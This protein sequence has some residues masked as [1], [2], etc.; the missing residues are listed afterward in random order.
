MK[1]KFFSFFFLVLILYAVITYAI[2]LKGKSC[3]RHDSPWLLLYGSCFFLLSAA[4]PLGRILERSGFSAIAVPFIWAGSFWFAAVVYLFLSILIIDLFRI[5]NALFPFFPSFL[6]A[7]P[8]RTRRVTAWVVCASVLMVIFAGYINARIPCLTTLHLTVHKRCGDLRSLHIVSVSD[9]H[10]GTI[11]GRARLEK[12][13][14]R[15]NGLDPDLVLLPG[16]LLDEDVTSL[17]REDLGEPFKHIRSR[18]G[19]FGVTGNH[20][21]I[22][23]VEKACAYLNSCQVMMLRDQ[24][25]KVDDLFCL[26]G[27]EDR[28]STHFASKKRKTLQELMKAVDTELPVIVMDHQPFHLDDV[29]RNQVDIQLSGHT[30][31][32]QMWP[33]NYITQGI[34]EIS[35]GYMKKDQTHI[36]VSNGVGTWGPPVRI[37]NRP[38]IVEIFLHFE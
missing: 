26:V 10:L 4:F 22:G 18:F 28:S 38:E 15:I 8:E 33:L 17:K 3:F 9:I 34:F 24:V 19:V 29:V 31:H 23:G 2:Y 14:E 30:H 5:G 1:I 32:G 36:Y 13:V 27:R 21:Y 6:T 11:V 35:R 7:D 16:D 37:G 25:H 12:I 20:E